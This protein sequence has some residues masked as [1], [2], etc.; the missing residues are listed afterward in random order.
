MLIYFAGPLFNEAERD[1]NLK[2]ATTLEEHGYKVFLPQR[3]GLGK[4][5]FNPTSMLTMGMTEE[6]ISQQIFTTDRDRVFEADVLLFVLDGRV[7]DEGACVE[8][9]MAYGQKYLLQKSTLLVGLHT[10]WRWVFPWT[11][12]NPLIECALDYVVGTEGELLA[13]LNSARKSVVQRK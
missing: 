10:D 7:P 8:L 13:V 4:D 11:Q 12:L 5:D 3:D 9:G 6:E 2:L 1:F